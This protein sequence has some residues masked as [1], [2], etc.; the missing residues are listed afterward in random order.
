MFNLLIGYPDEAEEIEIAKNPPGMVNEDLSEVLGRKK[1]LSLQELVRRVP[2]SDSLLKYSVRLVA[3]SRPENKH[4]PDF[5]K[6]WVSWG[7]SPRATQYLILAAKTHAL[8]D[9]R[10]TPGA[11]DVKDIAAPVLRHRIIT[12]FNAEAEGITTEK[13]VDLLL[14]EMK[15]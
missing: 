1:I 3:M 11:D 13:I 12:N 6:E 7:A 15:E 9:G 4:A 2:V 5:V 10:Y 8:L 14:K